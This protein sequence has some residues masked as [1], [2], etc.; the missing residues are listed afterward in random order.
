MEY[1]L[2]SKISRSM[3][4]LYP[5]SLTLPSGELFVK[6]LHYYLD[7]SYLSQKIFEID[8]K[9]NRSLCLTVHYKTAEPTDEIRQ[10]RGANADNHH[11]LQLSLSY[12]LLGM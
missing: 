12:W 11:H 3:Y 9:I 10:R 8:A 4:V 2:A 7:L 1:T 6:M 5:S